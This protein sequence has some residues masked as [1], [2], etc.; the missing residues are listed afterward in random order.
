MRPEDIGALRQ[1]EGPRVSPDGTLVA[2]TVADV[3]VDANGY[4]RRIW[5]ASTDG[6]LPARPFSAG[7]KD[8]LPRWSPDGLPLAF[9]RNPPEGPSELCVL[10]VGRGGER[11]VVA[12]WPATPSELAWSPESAYLGFVARDPD[13]QR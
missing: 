2:F 3:D 11:V 4:R 9:G 7:P 13:P 5:L 8:Q 1:V 6:T 10:P 12:T